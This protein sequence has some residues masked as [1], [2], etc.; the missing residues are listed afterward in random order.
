MN[1]HDGF[2]QKQLNYI[3]QSAI[4][5]KQFYWKFTLNYSWALLSK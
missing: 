1:L 5:I 2:G 4:S 3:K